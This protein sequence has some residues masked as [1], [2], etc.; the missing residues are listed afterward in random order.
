MDEPRPNVQA[1]NIMSPKPVGSAGQALDADEH[2]APQTAHECSVIA[3][4]RDGP[5]LIVTLGSH[6]IE[7]LISPQARQLAYAQRFKH[8]YA[9]AGI[10]A[11]SGSYVPTEEM[12]EAQRQGRSVNT[13]HNDYCLTPGL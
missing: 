13:W 10:D 1:A 11:G 12:T 4:R 2:G 7:H 3:I 6:S 9:T 8:G 5:N